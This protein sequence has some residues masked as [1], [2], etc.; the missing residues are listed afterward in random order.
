MNASFHHP[1]IASDMS[2]F[3]NN[4]LLLSKHFFDNLLVL[5]YAVMKGSLAVL[6]N[7]EMESV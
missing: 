3:L 2:D 7:Y 1:I 5:T 4:I 6:I